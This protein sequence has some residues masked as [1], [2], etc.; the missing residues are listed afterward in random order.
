MNVTQHPFASS[1]VEK[2]FSD[3]CFSTALETSGVG[4][5]AR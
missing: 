4:K 1:A 5:A 2:P 3:K